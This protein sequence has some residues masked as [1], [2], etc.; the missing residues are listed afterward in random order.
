MLPKPTR[1]VRVLGVETLIRADTVSIEHARVERLEETVPPEEPSAATAAEV[2]PPPVQKPGEA[3][4]KDLVYGYASIPP[5]VNGWPSV[6]DRHGRGRRGQPRD[7]R[8]AP[9]LPPPSR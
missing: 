1:V 8:P 3:E 5:P 2:T 9:D 7:T 6:S 4:A